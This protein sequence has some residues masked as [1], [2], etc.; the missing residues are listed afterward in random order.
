MLESLERTNL[1]LVTLDDE[2]IWYRYHHLFAELLQVRLAHLYRNLKP[3][4]HLRAAAWLEKNNL[5]IEAVNQALSGGANE[6]A[7][8]MVEENTTAL[9]A[10]GELKA[11]M[12]WIEALPVEIRQA[13]PR[14]CIHQAYALAFAGKLKEVGGLLQQAEQAMQS[15]QLG[16]EEIRSFHGSISAI[17][18]MVAV[19]AGQDLEG[20][21]QAGYA[22]TVLPADQDWDRS[23]VAWA[24]GYAERSLGHLKE[25]RAAFEEMVRLAR[26]MGNPWTMV[27]GLMDL[28]MVVRAQ[29]QLGA[30][31]GLFEEALREASRHGARG[32]GYI[33]RMEAGLASILY[34]QNELEAAGQLLFDAEAHI[35][36]WPNPNHLA[37]ACA[38][39]SRVYLAE[40]NLSG[41]RQAIVQADQVC[42]AE[43]TVR[44]TRRIVEAGMVRLWIKTGLSAKQRER[45]VMLENRCTALVEAWRE[46][47]RGPFRESF[48]EAAMISVLMLA[49]ISLIRQSSAEELI[50]LRQVTEQAQQMG[51]VSAAVE[52][53]LL[54]ALVRQKMSASDEKEGMASLE[55]ALRL[56]QPGGY[57]RT[58][59]DEERPLQQMLIRWQDQAGAHPLRDYAQHL[60]ALFDRELKAN[61]P[62]S[63]V[64]G[65]VQLLP[66][67][68]S[69]RE[70]E[71]LTLIAQG[72]TNDGIARQLII[73]TGTVKA[74]TAAIYRK[75]DVENRTE[76]V[77]RARQYHLLP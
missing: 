18:A 37:Y 28:A 38:V 27:S 74:H 55:E 12:R 21:S 50:L 7:A 8:R 31:R 29:G 1:F 41:A 39:H 10:Q 4:L 47:V 11:L 15:L 71:V 30:A 52:A 49:R 22:L 66:E 61:N 26:K 68:L 76:A 6:Q 20:L 3:E 73:S 54:T 77:A 13:R 62:G 53:L 45:D 72:L 42:Q 24:R 46:E 63:M 14:L 34:E 67:P 75:L 56:A 69:Q 36:Q 60:L 43:P 44:I 65:P 9:L 19:M 59:L 35:G 48:D 17:R 57:V 16:P 23:T 40:N 58:F 2:R 70:I 33:A 51:N 25:A 32:L 64:A 5:P